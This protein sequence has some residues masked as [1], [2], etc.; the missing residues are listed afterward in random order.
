MKLFITTLS[1][2][3]FFMVGL[4]AQ[5]AAD[6]SGTLIANG[7]LDMIV[8]VIGMVVMGIFGWLG[9][10]ARKKAIQLGIEEDVIDAAETAVTRIYHTS[11]A[12][13]K[14]ISADHKITKV[15]GRALRVEAWDATLIEL[16][17]PALAF[18]KD[19]GLA[20]GEKLFEIIIAKFK[21]K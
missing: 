20:Y 4:F 12:K 1:F 13:L 7:Y 17:G 2:L 19:K 14:E 21:K 18:A 10:K 6:T 5:E 3:A 8:K 15:E 11:Y 16:K 9:D